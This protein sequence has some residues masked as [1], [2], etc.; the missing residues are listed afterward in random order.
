MPIPRDFYNRDAREVAR[1]LLG[2][3]LVRQLDGVA[4]RG[5][6]VET[7][8][9]RPG[10]LAS[11]ARRGKT[12]RCA[13]MFEAP[14][15]AYVYLTY[16]MHW[17][18]NAVCEPQDQPAA[19]LI[20]AVEPLAGEDV[21]SHN[22]PARPRKQWTSGPA[23]LTQAMAI[24]GEQNRADLTSEASEVWVE[25]GEPIAEEAVSTGPRIGMGTVPEPWFSMPWRWWVRD[26]PFVSR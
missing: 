17:L 3:I 25:V 4:L 6:I 24:T 11:H 1:E 2:A 20:R 5:R 7:E 15:F 26:N 21:M 16:G 18:I 12:P 19:V 8:A 10:E 14:G 22:R 9:Y 23:K 13:P